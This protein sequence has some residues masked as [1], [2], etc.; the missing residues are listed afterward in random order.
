MFCVVWS[1]M[2]FS[3]V[4]GFRQ[5]KWKQNV[6]K[7]WCGSC[8]F[9]YMPLHACP[10]SLLPWLDSATHSVLRAAYDGRKSVWR[11]KEA[12]KAFPCWPVHGRF[13][14]IFAWEVYTS[15][16]RS[17]FWMRRRTLL[18]Y[19]EWLHNLFLQS[20][21]VSD[22]PRFRIM[23]RTSFVS[24]KK[25]PLFFLWNEGWST[26]SQHHTA[27]YHKHIFWKSLKITRLVYEWFQ[28]LRQVGVEV[29]PE[30]LLPPWALGFDVGKRGGEV[31]N[32]VG[33][34]GGF[35]ACQQCKVPVMRY[36]IILGAFYCATQ[37]HTQQLISVVWMRSDLEAILTPLQLLVLKPFPIR[38]HHLRSATA[39]ILKLMSPRRH[40]QRR[41]GNGP[42]AGT[43][44]GGKGWDLK[45]RIQLPFQL[46]KSR[47]P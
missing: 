23:S 7:D 43:G 4:T 27:K 28:W 3:R 33:R 36:S 29:D 47:T 44:W 34:W 16:F 45:W 40:C 2:F 8:R 35:Y 12:S 42:A 26:G 1:S 46:F 21:F 15:M 18:P 13:A 17:F 31:T 19:T 32:F 25:V 41:K 14:S 11:R 39:I 10:S 22:L 24:K 20:K 37:L 30:D 6:R 38:A 9:I 5:N